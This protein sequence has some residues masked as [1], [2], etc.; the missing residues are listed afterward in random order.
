MSFRPLVGRL[1]AWR[2]GPQGPKHVRRP[3]AFL[4]VK[5]PRLHRTTPQCHELP[6]AATSR[7]EP[8]RAATSRHE[9]RAEPRCRGVRGLAGPLSPLRLPRVAGSARDTRP[10]L[11][12]AAEKEGPPRRALSGRRGSGGAAR[13]PPPRGRGPHLPRPLPAPPP[14]RAASGH[15]SPGAGP[16]VSVEFLRARGESPGGEFP[17]VWSFSLPGGGP[18]FFPHSGGGGEARPRESPEVGGVT[19]PAPPPPRGAAEGNP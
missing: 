1:R 4:A 11:Q 14:P 9:L 15:P 18:R 10:A 17:T 3:H 6:R 8:P 7:Q 19:L 5:R 16:T 2:Q 12:P 13:C